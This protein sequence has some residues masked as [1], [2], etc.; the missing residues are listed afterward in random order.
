LATINQ[1][2]QTDTKEGE[3]FMHPY[4][5]HD[6]AYTIEQ[7]NAPTPASIKVVG[8]GGGGCNALDRMIAAGVAGVEYIATNTDTQALQHSHA[9][10]QI[11]IGPE[12]ARGL[13]SGGDPICG[14]ASA[15]ESARSLADSLQGADLVFLTCGMGGGTGTGAAPIIAALAQDLGI[16]T[17]GVVTLPFA[18]EGRHRQRIAVQGIE[19]LRPVVDT[20]IVIPN[21]R[22]LGTVGKHTSLLEAFQQTDQVLL[23]GIS[24][25]SDLITRRGIINVDFA[26]ARSILE[27]AGTAWMAIGRGR[28]SGRVVEAVNQALNSPLLEVSI[29]GARGL[30]CNIVGGE[31]LGLSEM[32]DGLEIVRNT[33]DSD[34]NIIHGVVIDPRL[35]SGDVHL[36]LIATGFDQPTA[37]PQPLRQSTPE[38][39]AS[40]AEPAPP[41]QR[42]ALTL[43]HPAP[44]DNTSELDIPP[45]LRKRADQRQQPDTHSEHQPHRSQSQ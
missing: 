45:F 3:Y 1:I 41:T 15:E 6:S 20:L 12:L 40:S 42:R 34:A 7:H 37:A 25:I 23:H 32:N 4:S 21:D 33:V 5:E 2:K 22:L 29:N 10:C 11:Q 18:F 43:A 8:I 9:D 19:Q 31:D 35:K 30:L 36:T 13:G 39:Q 28:G 44:G 27:R 16:L 24:G 26:D 38:P 14:Q 17:I